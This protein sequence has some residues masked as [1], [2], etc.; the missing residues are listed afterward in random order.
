MNN[1][2]E[3]NKASLFSGFG[4]LMFETIGSKGISTLV[5]LLLA[6]LLSPDAFGVVALGS[7]FILFFSIIAD[8]GFSVVIIQRKEIENQHLN[9]AFWGN[10]GIVT[11]LSG[12][13]FL[14]APF[15]GEFYGEPMLSP[16]IRLL[17][18][19]LIIQSTSRVHEA[20]LHK[21]LQ[22]KALAKRRVI[23][24][25]ISGMAGIIAALNGGG[26]WS[27][28]IQSL[29]F[30][31]I[32]ALWIWYLSP[33]RPS[34][35]FSFPAFKELIS[36]GYKI[37]LK[38]MLHELRMEELIIGAML[39]V[40]AVG[41]YS[42]AKKIFKVFTEVL[43]TT[44][45]KL[46]FPVFS[47]L[48]EDQ[49]KNHK[50]LQDFVRYSSYYLLPAFLGLLFI[51]PA[52]VSL[53][54]GDEWKESLPIIQCF[55]LSGPFLIHY[56]LFDNYVLS[57]GAY[58]HSLY[59]KA[60]NTAIILS[61][62]A[63]LMYAE[64]PLYST[65]YVLALGNLTSILYLF[66]AARAL[67]P[68][69]VSQYLTSLFP[70]II[71]SLLILGLQYKSDALFQQIILPSLQQFLELGL[72]LMIYGGAILLLLRIKNPEILFGLIRKLKGFI[73]A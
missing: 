27:L 72:A 71:C 10:L 33:F 13:I 63:L 40:V 42:I 56:T 1:Q 16:L 53:L 29:S 59:G 6:R 17:L 19:G 51:I 15:I 7:V 37:I 41:Y 46:S 20:L 28:V 44:V 26:L 58:N 14:L 36:F 64:Y 2:K 22:F 24:L 45:S 48:K 54:I 23:A 50:L 9:A 34:W 38:K 49:R 35:Q 70:G 4:W 21:H 66:F 31:G 68:L 55:L 39:N 5:F 25:F 47:K 60:I 11:L 73:K 8:L 67:L 30:I 43:N 32:E 52:F 57:Q 3:I 18:I 69:S 12:I 65:G 61:G 62:V